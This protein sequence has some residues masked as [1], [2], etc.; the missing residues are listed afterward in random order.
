MKRINHIK[1]AVLLA[2]CIAVVSCSIKED[3]RPCPC[4]LDI[5][6]SGCSAHAIEVN[7]SAW[8]TENLFSDKVAVADYPDA[9][10]R[11][12]TKG[13]VM[14]SAY[15]G[16][17]ESI[18]QGSRIIIPEGKQ[19]DMLRV[20]SNVVDCTGE[21][22]QDS[23][24]LNRQYATVYLS[25]KDDVKDRS[26]KTMEVKG[27]ICGI[28]YVTLEP[29]EGDFRFRTDS[30]DEGIWM[31]RLPR[32]RSDSKLSLMTIVDGK[33]KDEFPLNEWIA[34]SG[35]SWLDKDL[36][37]IYIDVDYAVG[38][39]SIVIQGWLEGDYIDIML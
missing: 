36:K 5:D 20:H 8:S 28:D 19:S 1:S 27:G 37:D 31:F 6:I 17:H 32:Q 22:A 12:V 33:E 15:S 38:K 29:V 24:E 7:L 18:V 3:R 11:T 4:W 21:F 26:L 34:K 30:N 16:L 25:L 13:M 10:E 23:V 14:T 9:Y 39:V 35:Y 2:S